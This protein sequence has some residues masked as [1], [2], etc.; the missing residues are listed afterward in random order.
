MIGGS[1]GTIGVSDRSTVSGYI[2]NERTGGIAI[3]DGH[4]TA[5]PD[6][7]AVIGTVDVGG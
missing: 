3:S 4:G 7:S 6:S 1:D 5:V 2:D